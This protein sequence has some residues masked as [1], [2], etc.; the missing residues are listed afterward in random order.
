MILGD[1]LKGKLFLISVP[2]VVC[3]F[4]GEHI[5]HHKFETQ[6]EILRY[7]E[8]ALLELLS[9]QF[10]EDYIRPGPLFFLF[11]T[12]SPIKNMD[13]IKLIISSLLEQ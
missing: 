2:D 11:H 6:I 8:S 5:A 13:S 4:S 9:I 12:F 1:S 3:L 7:I 10:I